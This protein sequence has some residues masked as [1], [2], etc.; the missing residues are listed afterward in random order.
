M[1]SLF[2]CLFVKGILSCFALAFWNKR[3]L[4]EVASPEVWF[5]DAAVPV[6]AA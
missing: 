5:A 3:E 1:F 4:F 2:E 6:L